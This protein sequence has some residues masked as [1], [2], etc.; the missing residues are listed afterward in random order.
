MEI[1][2]DYVVRLAFCVIILVI[3]VWAYRQNMDRTPLLVGIAFG[4]FGV[5]Y[6]VILIGLEGIHEMAIL[7]LRYLGYLIVVY[8]LYDAGSK[9]MEIKIPE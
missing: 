6:L 5:Y 1:A 7:A 4:L 8:A 3:G 2:L 9:G